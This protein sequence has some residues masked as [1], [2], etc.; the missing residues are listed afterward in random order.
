[1]VLHP[2][3]AIYYTTRSRNALFQLVNGDT[4]IN[5]MERKL[6]PTGI[7]IRFPPGF[8]A[9]VRPRSGLAITHGIVVFS[10]RPGHVYADYRGEIKVILANFGDQPFHIKRGEN[11]CPND[12]PQRGAGRMDSS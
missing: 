5:P 12:Y 1:M 7:S 8:E 4:V 11:N 2:A 9:Q 6:I 3:A 10:M